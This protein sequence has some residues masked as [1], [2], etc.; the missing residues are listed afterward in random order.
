M[1]KSDFRVCQATTTIIIENDNAAAMTYATIKPNTKI[2]QK[3][4]LRQY[5]GWNGV[6]FVGK[7]SPM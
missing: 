3:M 6:E 5:P 4:G 1:R 2:S 7:N